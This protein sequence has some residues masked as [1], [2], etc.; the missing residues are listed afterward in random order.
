MKFDNSVP[1]Y[2]EAGYF[3][4]TSLN[5]YRKQLKQKNYFQNSLKSCKISTLKFRFLISLELKTTA[6]SDQCNFRL[7]DT[8][9]N[10]IIT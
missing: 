5:Y 8:L 2:C 7:V 9:L 4:K 10:N 6:C 1:K 3:V